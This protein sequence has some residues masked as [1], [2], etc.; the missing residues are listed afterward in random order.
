MVKKYC[1]IQAY[2][3]EKLLES[4]LFSEIIW[5]NRISEDQEGELII[6]ENSHRYKVKKTVPNYE[7]T[8]KT[9]Q[10]MEYKIKVKIGENSSNCYLKYKFNN[11]EWSLFKNQSQSIVFALVS[12]KNENNPEIIFTKNLKLNEL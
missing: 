1:K 3:Y 10:D 12:L 7:F 8:V 4:H 9:D 6:L 2:I 11:S 5:I